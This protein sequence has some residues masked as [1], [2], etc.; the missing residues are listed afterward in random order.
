MKPEILTALIGVGG[1]AVGAFVGAW[2]AYLS[3]KNQHIQLVKKMRVERTFDAAENLLQLIITMRATAY[4]T[5]G[6]QRFEVALMFKSPSRLSE[7]YLDFQRAWYAKQYLIDANSI[8]CC[9]L[10]HRYLV[11]TFQKYPDLLNPDKKPE[12]TADQFSELHANFLTLLAKAE[13]SL[14]KFLLHD[15]EKT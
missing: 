14:K 11:D 8:E 15:L 10:I 12:F 4:V 2:F 5:Y 1:T 6:K 7:W 13:E 3:Q 9:K